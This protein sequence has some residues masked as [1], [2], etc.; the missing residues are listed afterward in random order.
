[1][2]SPQVIIKHSAQVP[3]LVDP[4]SQA[5]VWLEK[6]LSR[7]GDQTDDTQHRSEAEIVLQQ[8]AKLT[9]KLELA[10]RFGKTVI[11]KE[12]E[13]VP[14]LLFPLLRREFC[15]NGPRLQVLVGERQ[16]EY[17]ESFRVFLCTRNSS[18]LEHLP[19]NA[20][21][22]VAR[23]NFSITRAGLEAQLLGLTLSRE[24]PELESRKSELLQKEDALKIKMAELETKLLEQLADS[25]GNILEN[26]ALIRSLEETKKSSITIQE[27]LEES[28]HLQKDLDEQRE[29]YRSLA[30]LGSKLFILLRDFYT[31]GH[32][33]RFSLGFFTELFN[34]VLTMEV[35]AANVQDKIR[36]F[37][38]QLKVDVLSRCS[39]SIFKKDR[40][41]FGVHL[42]HGISSHPKKGQ[43]MQPG[44]ALVRGCMVVFFVTKNFRSYRC[45]RK[46]RTSSF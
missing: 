7:G 29:V 25:Q 4:N 38:R 17:T 32:M 11:I 26:T 44:M 37:E 23:V 18:A 2:H 22:L 1:M 15:R 40:L 19:P 33:Y 10:V 16:C 12:A 30:T 42:V 36:S 3:F 27:A 45:I 43:V 13:S 31:I 35:R 9:T 21:C 5:I 8:D 24:K 34:N 28:S 14:A 46:R 39:R 41:T 20:S 6:W